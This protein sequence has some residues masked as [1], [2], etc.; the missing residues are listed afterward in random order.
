MKYKWLDDLTVL[1]VVILLTVGITSY[2]I[3]QHVPS[4][5]P[6]GNGFI[7]AGNLETQ[8]YINSIS[9]WTRQKQMKLNHSKS[10]VMMYN[11]TEKYQFATRLT[12]ESENLEVVNQ[13]KL[14]GV[15]LTSDLK[16]NENTKHLVKRANSRMEI[17]RKLSSFNP[18]ISDMLTIYKLYIRSILEQSCVIWHS[19]LSEEN[20]EDLE[21]V[22]KNALRN[23]LKEKYSSYKDALKLLKLETLDDRRKKLLLVY[24]KQCTKIEQTKQLFP[25]KKKHHN[26]NT[27]SNETYEV[28]KTNT[29]RYRNSTVPFIQKLLNAESEVQRTPG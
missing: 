20:K 24:G 6:T 26:M 4:D 19:S 8:N 23:I 1:E 9:E 12:V 21:R 17:L 3:K 15:V 25:L 10:S 13:C 29:T 28:L 11:F 16:W 5:I 7:E 14:L 22:Q 18:P 2:N 27:R